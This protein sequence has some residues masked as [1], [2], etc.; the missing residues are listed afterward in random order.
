MI[1]PRALT[2]S[3]PR[4]KSDLLAERIADRILFQL[5]ETYEIKKRRD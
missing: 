1:Q 3:N 2:P 5:F 4:S